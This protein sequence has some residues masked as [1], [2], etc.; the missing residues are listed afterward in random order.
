MMEN[1]V[2]IDSFS[3]LAKLQNLLENSLNSEIPRWPPEL[4]ANQCRPNGPAGQIGR[5]WLAGNSEGHRGNSKF[6][7]LIA[8]YNY[9]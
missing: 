8:L 4:P 2:F 3:G 1:E 6:F 9:S 5:H 7:F